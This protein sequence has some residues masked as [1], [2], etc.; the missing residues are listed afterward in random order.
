MF[1]HIANAKQ[2][3]KIEIM[4]T[5]SICTS[6]RHEDYCIHIEHSSNNI[7]QCEEFELNP[8][9]KKP[10]QH[11]KT[12]ESAENFSGLCKNCMHRFDCMNRDDNHVVWHC[13]DYEF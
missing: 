9:E 4:N 7:L 8:V 12:T 11:D 5:N 1:F 3:K 2:S 10:I 6:C 13:E